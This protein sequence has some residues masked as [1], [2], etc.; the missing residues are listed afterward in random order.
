[1]QNV[2]YVQLTLRQQPLR[3]HYK[4]SFRRQE[5][6][7]RHQIGKSR[8]LLP[9]AFVFPPFLR[10]LDLFDILCFPYIDSPAVSPGVG[11]ILQTRKV[12]FRPPTAQVDRLQHDEV[13]FLIKV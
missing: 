9:P 13:Q 5:C 4:L 1:M 7:G 10:I 6:A 2:R 8:K 11:N 3:N 12:D